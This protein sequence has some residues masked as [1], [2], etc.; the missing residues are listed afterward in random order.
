MQI[1]PRALKI[2]VQRIEISLPES[3]IL[4]VQFCLV[5]K[6][7]MVHLSLETTGNSKSVGIV[8]FACQDMKDLKENTFLSNEEIFSSV[9]QKIKTL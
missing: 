8:L 3:V 7:Y 9:I 4:I 6:K 5:R 2:P 1:L